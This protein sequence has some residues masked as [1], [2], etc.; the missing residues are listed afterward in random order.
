LKPIKE[1][2]TYPHPQPAYL[3]LEKESPPDTFLPIP[4]ETAT[5]PPPL[6]L[7][8]E[9][10]TR[11]SNHAV[12]A[13]S[14]LDSSSGEFAQEG[15]GPDGSMWWRETGNEERPTGVVV[16]WTLTRGVTS[17]GT[18][19]WEEKYWEA[20][21]K[22]DYKELGSEKSGRDARGNVWREFW[23]ECMWQ[24]CVFYK[25]QFINNGGTRILN[26]QEIPRNMWKYYIYIIVCYNYFLTFQ[27]NLGYGNWTN[28][29]R[30]D[31]R[32]MGKE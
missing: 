13:A 5:S 17:E 7:Y 32:Q 16:K 24:V 12:E 18:V 28:T 2:G 8:L 10:D 6:Q 26:F 31:R 20:S 25:I 22:Y 14:A 15:I 3:L 30:E 23:K 11:F 21:D 1:S 19:E 9:L 29:H 27:T 4:F